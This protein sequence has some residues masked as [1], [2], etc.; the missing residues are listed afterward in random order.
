MS[1]NRNWTCSIQQFFAVKLSVLGCKKE[2]AREKHQPPGFVA[3]WPFSDCWKWGRRK[4]PEGAF[5]HPNQ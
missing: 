2:K 4:K 1:G 3:V 5:Y